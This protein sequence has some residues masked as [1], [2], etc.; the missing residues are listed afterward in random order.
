MANM[1]KLFR[2]SLKPGRE[3]ML[4]PVTRMT[5]AHGTDKDFIIVTAQVAAAI[6]KERAKPGTGLDWKDAVRCVTA[7]KSPDVLLRDKEAAKPRETLQKAPDYNPAVP[8]ADEAPADKVSELQ[9]ARGEGRAP[10][11]DKLTTAE[12]DECARL[13]GVDPKAYTT[14][15]RLKGAIKKAL[16]DVTKSAEA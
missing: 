14:T 3:G 11:V 6:D 4:S 8:S 7:G 13:V 10:D 2:I 12:L 5:N 16:A 9:A 15:A 1:T